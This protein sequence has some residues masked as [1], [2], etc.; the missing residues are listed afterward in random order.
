MALSEGIS[1]FP[2]RRSHVLKLYGRQKPWIPCRYPWQRGLGALVGSGSS[3]ICEGFG[4]SF[5]FDKP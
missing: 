3:G 5:R 4:G 1:D 2:F